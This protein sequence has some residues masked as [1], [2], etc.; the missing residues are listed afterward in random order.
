MEQPEPDVTRCDYHLD[1]SSVLSF[2]SSLQRV[3]RHNPPKAGNPRSC[4]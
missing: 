2:N 3:R 1:T 4:W